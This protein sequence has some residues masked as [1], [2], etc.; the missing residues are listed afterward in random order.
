MKIG[1]IGLESMGQHMARKLIGADV[2]L[3]IY[4]SNFVAVSVLVEAGA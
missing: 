1:F 3:L 4:D 2:D